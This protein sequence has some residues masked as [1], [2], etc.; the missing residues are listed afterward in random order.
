MFPGGNSHTHTMLDRFVRKV[1]I[2]T[3]GG[4]GIGAAI[5]RRLSSEGARVVVADIDQAA[6]ERTA[7]S[8]EH[9]LA[10]QASPSVTHTT[11]LPNGCLQRAGRG[12]ADGRE[13]RSTSAS[14]GNR[15]CELGRQG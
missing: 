9:G 13:R 11:S 6:A 7:E 14:P 1:A 10:L 12:T 3:G 8:L 2:V 15:R 4:N 5:C